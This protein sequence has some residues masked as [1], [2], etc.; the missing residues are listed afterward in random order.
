MWD[1]KAQQREHNERLRGWILYFLYQNRPK[2]LEMAGLMRLLDRRNFP[3]SRRRLA[4]EV[5]YLRSLRLVRVFP[6]CAEA[7]M[8]EV[9]QAKLTQRYAEA[10]HDGEMP[11]TLSV[12]VTTAGINLQDGTV[13]E[14]AGILRVE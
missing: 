13:P 8:D 11:D 4:A 9:Q 14:M 7:E 1:H 12:R 10:D 6:T 3:L 2:P 5:D